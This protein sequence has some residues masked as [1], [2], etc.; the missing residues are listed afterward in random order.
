M[1][2][3]PQASMVPAPARWMMGMGEHIRVAALPGLFVIFPS[4]LQH[5]VIAH[6]GNQS[7]ISVSFNVRLTYPSDDEA[8]SSAALNGGAQPAKLSFTVP[9]HHQ[10]EFLDR[11]KASDMLVS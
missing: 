9:P 4:W 8:G 1:D 7:R 6:E 3:R 10:E 2:P 11:A 5:Y